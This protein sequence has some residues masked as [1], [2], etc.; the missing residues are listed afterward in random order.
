[1]P[2]AWPTELIGQRQHV[3]LQLRD[4]LVLLGGWLIPPRRTQPGA[5]RP[6]NGHTGPSSSAAL[7]NRDDTPGRLTKDHHAVMRTQLAS[8]RI[9]TSRQA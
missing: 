9:K 4:R 6:Q 7:G 1:V 8:I 5:R 2:P 3:N